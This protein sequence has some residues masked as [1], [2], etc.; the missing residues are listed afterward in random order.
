M[1][2]NF[3][4]RPHDTSE[5]VWNFYSGH[6]DIM[7]TFINRFQWYEFS[8]NQYVSEF[9]LHVDIETTSECN[10]NCPMCF[11]S[12]FRDLGQMDWDVF[13]KIVDE[14]HDQGVY[15]IRLSWRGEVLTHPRI[16]DMIDYATSKIN[17]VS[18]LTNTMF[19]TKKVAD[20]IIDKGLAYIGCSF[21]GIGEVY[22][23]VR[24]PAKY[25]SSRNKLKYLKET[26]DARGLQ[27]PQIRVTTIW[28]AISRDPQAYYDALKDVTDL[29]VVNNYK[30]FTA[31]PKPI[32]GFVCQYP[33][34][35]LIVA[36]DGRVQCCTGWNSDDITLGNIKEKTLKDLWCGE[37]LSRLRKVHAQGKR[38]EFAGCASCRHGNELCDQ[39]IPIEEIVERKH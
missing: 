28:P 35:R 9:P 1:K 20:F 38:M 23:K 7:S 10:M 21:D 26:R 4:Q 2:I 6:G 31:S 17:N 25:E 22:N 16:F 29:I 33:W 24:E 27:N 11:R 14:C 12:Q 30:D 5:R 15:S 34:E 8:R 37:K 13:T 19:I 3:H 18:F 39:N 32:D 36:H